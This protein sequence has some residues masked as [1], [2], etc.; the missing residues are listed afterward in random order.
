MSLHYA[1]RPADPGAHLF[2]VTLIVERPDPAGQRLMLPA[3]IPGSYMIREFARHIVRIVAFAGDRKVKL[4]KLDKHTWQAAPVDGALTLAY[5]V[6]AWD[7][8]VRAAHLDRTH[9][10]FNGT[11]VFLLPLG[12]EAEDC[13]VDI[14]P[15]AGREYAQWKLVT[16]LTPARGTRRGGFG[17]YTAADY[18]ELI[19]CPVEMG[20][21]CARGVR[22]ARCAA[23]DRHHRARAQAR[24]AAADARP[25]ARLRGADPLLC[26]F[27]R[28]WTA[29]S[30]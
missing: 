25:G 20:T 1:I 6:Y 24:P 28:S 16:G 18:H 29:V 4:G 19:D 14:L 21:V 2:H 13:V 30:V 22:G 11:S 26:V 7:L 8:S 9:G 10:F 15:P 5:E 17:T 27:Q 12:H 3:W 23:R